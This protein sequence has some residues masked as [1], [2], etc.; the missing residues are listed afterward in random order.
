M[1]RHFTSKARCLTIVTLFLFSILAALA[2]IAQT[3][4]NSADH[5]TAMHHARQQKSGALPQDGGNP[6]FLGG[7]YT[8]SGDSASESV[9]IADVNGD[10][11]PDLIVANQGCPSCGDAFVSVLLGNGDGT[12]QNPLE[13][14]SGGVFTIFAAVADV[15]H[16]GKPDIILANYY[17]GC[18]SGDCN[19]TVSVLLG[20][21]NGTF[22][23]AVPYSLPAENPD[24]LAVADLN[25]DGKLDIVVG[26]W[27]SGIAVL[28]GNGDGTFQPATPYPNL[29]QVLALSIADVN[30]DGKPDVIAAGIVQS[31]GTVTV[32]LGK[33]DGTFQ[34]AQTFPSGSPTG[35]W[36]SAV[37]VAD[38]NGDG[39]PDLVVANYQNN[40]GVLLGKG[41]GTFQPVVLYSSGGAAQ[42]A[43]VTDVGGDGITDVIVGNYTGGSSGSIGVLLGNGDGTLQPVVN[44]GPLGA[45]SVAAGDLNGDGRP[46]VAVAT[47]GGD[48]DLLFND[49]G[50]HTPTATAVTSSLNPVPKD[51]YV[52]YTATVTSQTGTATGTVTFYDNGTA[53]GTAGLLNNQGSVTTIYK[54]KHKGDG[55]L[56]TIVA[57]YSGDLLNSP[58]TGSTYE[59]VGDQ[60][61]PSVTALATSGSP[62]QLGQPVTFTATVTSPYYSGPIPDGEVVTFYNGGAEIGTGTTTGGVAVFTTSSLTARK[63]TIKAQYPGDK[64]FKKSIGKVTQVVEK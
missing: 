7:F 5:R 8:Y 56:H 21:G 31:T 40:V 45:W 28:M 4:A 2:S 43:V 22:Q 33:G 60:P 13:F 17:G 42:S 27:N 55:G 41:D 26:L 34:S 35:Y 11:K 49:T 23:P 54:A 16:D 10:G 47:F 52:T 48:V 18:T 44:F 64:V 3:Q 36:A 15:N 46:D 39:K 9:A 38:M 30:H 51:E 50:P 19:G 14:D 25:G 24:A 32:L 57:N 59:G 1:T 62:S 29:G 20:N 6:L 61:F 12:F 63:H 58:S 37:A 53:I